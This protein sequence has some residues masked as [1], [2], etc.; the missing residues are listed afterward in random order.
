MNLFSIPADHHV[1]ALVWMIIHSIWQ[2]GSIALAMSFL[3]KKY[4]NHRASIRYNIALASLVMA[5]L[6][7]A[8]TFLYY[9]DAQESDIFPI[10]VTNMGLTTSDLVA[11]END[12]LHHLYSWIDQHRL[13]IFNIWLMGI[14]LFSMRFIFALGYVEF[15]SRTS[16]PILSLQTQ[17]S[18]EKLYKHLQI[19]QNIKIGESSYVKSPMILGFLKPIILF[20]LGV[21]NQLDVVE[22]EAILAHELAHF[23]RK[24]IYVNVIQ[25]IIEVLFY[26]HP[27]IWWISTNI[28]VEREN[29]CDDLAIQYVGNNIQY[30]KTLVKMQEMNSNI[31]P[32]LALNFSNRNSYFSNRIKRILN[33]TQTRN[34]LKEKIVTSLALVLL[35][36]IFSK[37]LTGSNKNDISKQ[38]AEAKAVQA[39]VE[40]MVTSDTMPQR[41]ESI[42][43]QKKTN[44]R[45][46]KIAMENGKVTDLEVDGKKI[47]EEDY[48]KYKD[49]IAEVKPGRMGKG[50]THMFYF[51]DGKMPEEFDMD[52]FKGNLGNLDE[53]YFDQSRLNEQMEKLQ[54]K[55]GGMQFELGKL[56]SMN[57]NFKGLDSFNFNFGNLAFPKW[58]ELKN[59]HGMK[60]FR[61]DDNG[62]GNFQFRD[63]TG[64]DFPDFDNED[65]PRFDRREGEA[66]F[67]ETIG[68]ALNRDGLLIP[69]QE[70]KIE[71][72]GKHLKING[73]K[74]PGNIW[75]K[76]K[77]IFEE[78]S[79]TTLQK[80]S[81]LEFKFQGKESKRK[82]RVY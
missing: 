52:M 61:F 20:P 53:L 24:D 40:V 8:A 72:S 80:N 25:T 17:Q 35:V 76:Y 13:T 6:T 15:L 58:E 28:K 18:F 26:Y 77:R 43:I 36:M 57:F 66:N 47:A 63:E 79:G 1:Q 29:C 19:R 54:G 10:L 32:V 75:N 12:G 5:F 60:L 2:F 65:F 31:S 4:Q 82:Y 41:R 49:I 81:K 73:E 46:V 56:D 21:I 67:S 62:P 27:A 23:V 71:L 3:L 59:N 38:K 16:K 48:D 55:L 51:G 50:N 45:E 11:L 70:N 34:Y 37:D 7:A 44:D 74:Q 68:N 69:G 78:N 33:M 22:V 30:A 64:G 42:T 39:E 9:L 14:A